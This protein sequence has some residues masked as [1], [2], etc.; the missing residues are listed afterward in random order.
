M[1]PTFVNGNVTA[2]CPKCGVPT[3][4]SYREA[5]GNEFGGYAIQKINGFHPNI[6]ERVIYKL[7]RCAVCSSPGIAAVFANNN[8]ANNSELAWF[9]PRS[10]LSAKLPDGVPEGIVQEVREAEACMSVGAWRGAAALLRSA[11]EKVLIANG[12]AEANLYRKIEAAGADG[13]I[14]SARRQRAQDLIRTL[15]NDVLH[16]EWRAVSQEEAE[17]AHHYVQRVLEDLYDDRDSVVGVLTEKGRHASAG[18]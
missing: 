5:G 7:M 9:W 1:R 13:V 10:K 18:V 12:Y 2:D 14:T 4:F 16:D 15:G 3:S 17:A 6:Y 11:L 8:Y